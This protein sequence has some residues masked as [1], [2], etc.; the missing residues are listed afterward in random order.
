MLRTKKTRRSTKNAHP[1]TKKTQWKK[2]PLKSA[3]SKAELAH[4][5]MQC[6][7]RTS[8]KAP[9]FPPSDLKL[10]SLP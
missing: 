1:D 2:P 3:G 5:A 6:P 9:C 4:R 8:F 7:T 10:R